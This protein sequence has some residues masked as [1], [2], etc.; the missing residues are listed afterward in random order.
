MNVVLIGSCT[1]LTG[2]IVVVE[3]DV[4]G[5]TVDSV[6]LNFVVDA[7]VV[8]PRVG[9]EVDCTTVVVLGVVLSVVVA[10]SVVESVGAAVLVVRRVLVD[11]ELVVTFVFGNKE[12]TTPIGPFRSISDSGQV[13]S[14]D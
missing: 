10:V 12:S 13:S 5:L 2:E 14:S 11:G 6:V 3:T 4:D 7:D 9:L 8:E 1:L